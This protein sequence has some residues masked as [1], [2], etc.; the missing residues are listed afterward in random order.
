MMKTIL[1]ALIASLL[2]LQT[3][4]AERPAQFVLLAFDNC[5]ENQTWKQVSEFLD[6][7]NAVQKDRLRFTFFLSAVGL[8]ASDKRTV[9]IDPLG[10]RGKSN[11]DFGGDDLTV[12]QRI[13]WIN[14]LHDS[15]NEIASH[16]VGHFDGKAWSVDQ[17]RHEFQQYNYILNNLI[18]IHGWTGEKA[19]RGQL[20]FAPKDLKGFRAPYLGGGANLNQV[21]MEN[22]YQY[23]TSDSSQ[24]WEP[25]TWPRKYPRAANPQGLWNFGLSFINIPLTGLSEA[26][27]LAGQPRRSKT[28]KIVSMD[29]NF[30][31]RQTGG[32][33]NKDPYAD[34]A[35]SDAREMLAGYLRSFVANYN[36]NRAPLN[37]GH[38]FELYRGG[39]YNRALLKFA[40]TV[41]GLPEVRC[42]TYQELT[43]FMNRAGSQRDEFQAGRFAKAPALKFEDL[44][45]KAN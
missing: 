27:R 35:E 43:D 29:Y 6:E 45:R 17:W 24:G 23:D 15:G 36:G 8:V 42:A 40:R 4:A 11:I 32:C 5:Q 30:C 3:L 7:M 12:L 19:R 39:A 13:A 31:Y 26:E 41:C 9:Y 22:G 44:W 37:I 16:A 34:Q 10:R 14:K 25:T 18:E 21:L 28:T 38:H 1:T 2:S 33:P 20:H